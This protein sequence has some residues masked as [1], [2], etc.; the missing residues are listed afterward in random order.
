VFLGGSASPTG[1]VINFIEA[2]FDVVVEAL[3]AFR[4]STGS[5]RFSVDHTKSPWVAIDALD[6]IEAPWTVETL[7]DCTHWTAYLNNGLGGGDPTASAD[8]IARQL[9][10]RCVMAMHAPPHGPGHAATQL[11][12]SGP[13]GVP[14]LM[15]VRT[16]TVQATDG[17]WT[18]MEAGTPQPWEDRDRYQARIKRQ[19]FDRELLVRY[20][21]AMD[22]AVD[23]EEFFGRAVVIR[24]TV[25]WPTRRVSV[26]E[27]NAEQG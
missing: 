11:W 8:E 6:P 19:R 2:P 12:I 17:R 5:R 9:E 22:M 16:L 24:E 15:Y 20:L 27:W 23:V 3:T 4:S 26:A 25:D 14:P 7:I 18:F 10:T 1:R 13:D 21:A